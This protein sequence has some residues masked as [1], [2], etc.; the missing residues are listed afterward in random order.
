M[1]KNIIVPVDMGQEER[2]RKALEIAGR[3]CDKG[4][5]L[6][7]VNVIEEVPAYVA[8]ELPADIYENSRKQVKEKLHDMAK[9]ASAKTE[10]EIRHGRP[11]TEIMNA[12]EEA[13][14]DLII[15]ASH[16]PEFADYLLGSTAARVVR[17]ANCAVLVDR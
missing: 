17:H 10:I 12:A 1:Y 6:H 14:A 4:G 7:L 8:A 3:L 9:S 2:G 5:T 13:G 16:R 11:A 15:V